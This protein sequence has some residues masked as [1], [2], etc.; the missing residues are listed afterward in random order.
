MKGMILGNCLT[1]LQ[2][3]V[4]YRNSPLAKGAL[5]K[6]EAEVEA[7]VEDANEVT[8]EGIDDI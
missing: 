5:T 6:I 4:Y 1:A 2:L 3:M 8:I 7:K